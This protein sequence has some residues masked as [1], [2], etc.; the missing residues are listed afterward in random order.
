MA[1]SEKIHKRQPELPA[2]SPLDGTGDLWGDITARLAEMADSGEPPSPEGPAP[3][4]PPPA[5][6]TP[7]TP[8][9][10]RPQDPTG[11]WD[12]YSRYELWQL[13]TRVEDR[14]T[15]QALEIDILKREIDAKDLAAKTTLKN[16]ITDTE[17]RMN[18]HYKS[19]ADHANQNYEAWV[20]L[21]KQV[22]QLKTAAAQRESEIVE[23][24]KRIADEQALC[25]QA[26]SYIRWNYHICAKCNCAIPYR[27]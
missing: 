10:A 1:E 25:K 22:E 18:Q 8:T 15:H 4:V 6:T 12:K 26:L 14:A 11:T 9:V 19:T 5:A 2:D 24:R 21:G 27:E 23:L 16:A 17:A 13:Y 7:G 20:H 3:V